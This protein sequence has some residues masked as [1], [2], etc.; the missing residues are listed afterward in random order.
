MNNVSPYVYPGLA[1]HEFKA[2]T[3]QALVITCMKFGVMPEQ[4]MSSTR[5]QEI[6]TCRHSLCFTLHKLMGISQKKVGKF[7]GKDHTSILH[8]WRT[9]EHLLQTDKDLRA[10]YRDLLLA[11]GYELLMDF[12]SRFTFS[13]KKLIK[14]EVVET[15]R[16]LPANFGEQVFLGDIKNIKQ[17]ENI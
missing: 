11:L 5:K 6:V 4:V 10:K 14:T 16:M 17:Y 9:F 7:L 15:K 1:I 2:N 12:N 3:Q 8:G 13:E